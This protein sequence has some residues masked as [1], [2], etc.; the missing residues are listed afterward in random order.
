M[1]VIKQNAPLF[2]TELNR[3]VNSE[4]LA[5]N[6]PIPS[7]ANTYQNQPKF[8]QLENISRNYVRVGQQK[9]A[10]PFPIKSRPDTSFYNGRNLNILNTLLFNSNKDKPDVITI[11]PLKVVG[12]Y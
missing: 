9:F 4:Y 12:F 6:I 2:Y 3:I 10:D 5:R 1:E 8:Q 11:N 7:V